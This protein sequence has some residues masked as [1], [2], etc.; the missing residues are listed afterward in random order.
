MLREMKKKKSSLESKI[1][2]KDKKKRKCCQKI[3]SETRKRR[4]NV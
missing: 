4:V 2:M 3:N 1:K